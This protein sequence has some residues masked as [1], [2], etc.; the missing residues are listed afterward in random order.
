MRDFALLVVVGLAAYFVV[1][2]T[3]EIN[4]ANETLNQVEVMDEFVSTN[5]YPWITK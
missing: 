3:M 4:S 2:T 1:S 5:A